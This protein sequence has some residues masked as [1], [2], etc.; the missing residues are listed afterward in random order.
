MF[1]KR[2]HTRC[3]II[4]CRVE[5]REK[6]SVKQYSIQP[7][8]KKKSFSSKTSKNMSDLSKTLYKKLQENSHALFKVDSYNA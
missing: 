1:S 8:K 6:E 5:E 2:F 3:E 7:G 4:T